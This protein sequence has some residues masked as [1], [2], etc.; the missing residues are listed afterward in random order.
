VVSR[1]SVRITFTYAALNGV[2]V[3]APD[4]KNAY[5]QAPSSQKDYVI[6][7]P[8][9]GLEHVGMVS[10][11]HRVLYGGKSAGRDFRNHLRSCMRHLDFA[12][13]PADPD[14][15]T[16]PATRSDRTEYY[17]YILL[18]TDDALCISENAE[19]VL[20][21]Q[22]GCYFPSKDK[23]VGPPKVYLGGHVRKVQL[24]SGVECWAFG[25][26]QYVRAAVTNVEM[27]LA[28]LARQGN[29]KWKLPAVAE[30]PMQTSYRPELDVTPELMPIE[31]SYYQSL[32]GV[33]RWIV[34]LGRV[35]ICLEGSMLSSH[36]ALPREGH[37]HQVFHIFAHLRTYHNSELV[38]DPSD[39]CIDDIGFELQ[40]WTS[41]EFGHLQG[42]EELPPNMPQSRGLG[43]TMSAKVD[44]D[45]A[46]DTV[47][48]RSRTGFLVRLNSSLIYW[49][50]RKQNSVESSSFGSEIIAMKQCCEYLQGL[51]YKLRMMGIPCE[52]H[53]YVDGDNQSV[54]ANT[55][56]TL[57]PDSTLKKKNQSIA[58][59]FIREGAA[60]DEWRTSYVNTHDNEAD[61]LTQLLPAGEKRKGFVPKILH[62]IFGLHVSRPVVD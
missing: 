28:K 35:D 12:S 54:L 6:C 8:E 10:L 41:S 33:L 18:Y 60:R 25:S 2:D 47:T 38:Y 50:P 13:C 3:W 4:I 19:S 26:S 5:L 24:A 7:G 14:V 55:A 58:Y 32:I 23:S 21:T 56:N 16:G 43:S 36:L 59:H 11:I 51:R 17:E 53:A 30:T 45:H 40:D 44:A 61:L 52:G 31:A 22:L 37:L 29:T 57:I 27:Y 1:D 46:A 39:P 15:W 34:E 49:S 20:R 42:D 9:F 62:H 48:R